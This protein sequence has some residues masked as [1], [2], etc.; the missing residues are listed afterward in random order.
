[1]LGSVVERV[2]HRAPCPVLAVP[3]RT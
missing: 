1:V 3:E 2:L